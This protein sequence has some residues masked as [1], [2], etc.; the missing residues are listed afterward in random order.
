V[1]T[2]ERQPHPHART[3]IP[4]AAVAESGV[5][6]P[7]TPA[8]AELALLRAP[9]AGRVRVV[10]ADRDELY[11]EAL[12]QAIK[13]QPSQELVGS[14][15][16]GFAALE[17]IRTLLP[18]VAVLDP[19]L[20]GL[21]GLRVLHAIE[22]DELPTRVVM[23]SAEL[24][25]R[26][27]H[28]ALAAGARGYLTRYAGEQEICAAITAARTGGAVISARLHPGVVAEICRRN[29]PDQ[30]PLDKGTREVV[31]LTAA[32][33]SPSEIAQQLY[34]SLS[35]VKSRLHCLY[36]ALGV[37]APTAAVAEAIRRHLID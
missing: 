2:A 28:D 17:L 13:R 30:P 23:L 32:G 14:G 29:S 6:A 37:N 26:R 25:E 11:L 9:A 22:R 35:T 16:D 7:A 10:L 15:K 31:E 20:P 24:E 12:S 21:D 1:N 36:K 8:P 27:P 4:V 34:L 19:S 33:F 5:P 18:D 3:P